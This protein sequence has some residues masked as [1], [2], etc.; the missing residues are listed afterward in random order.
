MLA[1]SFAAVVA[2]CAL[3]ALLPAC[4][5][6]ATEA[7]AADP[8]VKYARLLIDFPFGGQPV[9]WWRGRLAELSPGGAHADAALYRLTV[10]RAR[11]NGLVVDEAT[12]GVRPGQE[13]TVQI[14]VR[15]GVLQ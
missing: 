9:R 14:L 1:R 12:N 7:P 13:V 5:E 4:R 15:L 10:E 6:P 11:K 3:I 8:A 2:L